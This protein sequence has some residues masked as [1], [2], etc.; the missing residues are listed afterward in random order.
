MATQG[1]QA[2]IVVT[3]LEDGTVQVGGAIPQNEVAVR[4]MLDA[5]KGRCLAILQKQAA[6]AAQPALALP[7]G[8]LPNM[9]TRHGS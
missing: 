6:Q 1:V 3:L 8:P 2:Q 7:N 4:G 9:R 5:A